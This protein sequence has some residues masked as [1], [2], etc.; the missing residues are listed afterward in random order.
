MSTVRQI[1]KLLRWELRLEWRDKYAL[2]SIFL[3]VITTVVIAYLAVGGAL[4]GPVFNALY[5]I[6]L[7]FGATVAAGRSFL[8]EGGRR[9]FYYYTIADPLALLFSKLVFNAIII[10]LIGGLTFG[11]LSL[12][13]P[14]AVITNPLPLLLAVF[15]GGIGLSAIL[16]FVSAIT[17]RAGGSGT[18]MAILSFP[19][20]IPLLKLLL[21]AGLYAIDAGTNDIWQPIYLTVAVD[22]IA[23][24]VGIVLFPFVWRD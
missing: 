20:V 24:A 15:F 3:Y 11:L 16:T 19:L 7:F 2:G 8:R 23:L 13:A 10:W 6:I 21:D 17:A 12:F 22:L 1:Y 18:L 14:L 5:W 4:E 9:H